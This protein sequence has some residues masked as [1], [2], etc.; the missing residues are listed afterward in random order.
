MTEEGEYLTATQAR[1]LL[2][3]SQG[4]MTALIR[5][6]QLQTY[7]DPLNK[8]IKLI[9]KSDVDALL[10]QSA[11]QRKPEQIRE[12]ERKRD[13]QGDPKTQVAA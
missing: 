8:R 7:P 11:S 6:G 3:V 9:K 13:K 1:D 12:R 2:G 4:K 5:E 10:A